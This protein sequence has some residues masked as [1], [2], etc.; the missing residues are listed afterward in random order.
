MKF[1]R[2]THS[3]GS[4]GRRRRLSA[5]VG[6]ILTFLIVAPP[7]ALA[8]RG[9]AAEAERRVDSHIPASEVRAIRPVAVIGRE[10]LELSGAINVWDFVRGRQSYNSLGLSR[11]FVLGSGRMALLVDG[12]PASGSTTAIDLDAL[13]ISA[14]ER[15]EILNDSAAA[16]HGGHAIGG[17]INIVLRHDHEGAEVRL[18]AERPAGAGGDAEH[19]SALWGGAI[20]SGHMVIGADVFRRDEIRNADRDFSRARWTPGGEFADTAGVSVGGNTVFVPTDD[21]SIARSLGDCTG[22]AYTGVLTEPNNVPGTGC[23]FAYDEI[24]WSWE[25]RERNAAFVEFRHPVSEDT[26]LYA[27]AQVAQTDVVQARF[28]PSVGTFSFVP[29]QTLRQELAQDPEI[30]ALP[31]RLTVAHRFVGHGNRDWRQDVDDFELAAGVRGRFAGAVGYDAYVQLRRYDAP[32]DGDTFVSESAVQSAIEE[33]RYDL[34]N[35]LSTAPEHLAA[36]RETGLHLSRDRGTDQRSAG[37]SVDGTAFTLPG[38]DARWA[39]GTELAFD[40][41]RDLYRYRDV[42]GRSHEPDDVLGSGGVSYKGERRRWSIFAD[43]A[44]P[45]LTD[46]DLALAAR[47]DD[48]DDVGEALSYQVASRY[49]LSGNLALRG[50]WSEGSRAPSLRA[51]NASDSILYPYVCDTGTFTGDLS[52]CQRQQVELTSG[53]NPDLKPDEATSFSLGAEAGFGPLSL[54]ADWFAIA[55]SDAPAELSPQ[56]IIDLDNEGRLPPGAAVVRDGGLIARIESPK[57]NAGETD[58][59]GFNLGARTEWNAAGTDIAID[60]HWMHVT[61]YETRVAG[62]KQPGDYPR[63]RVHAS[64]RASR[65]DL[66]ATW[67]VYGKSGFWN[68]PRTGRYAGWFGHDVALRWRNPFGWSAMELTGGMHNV[69]DR[70]PSTDST[71]P[72]SSGADTSLDTVRGRTLFLT[73]GVPFDP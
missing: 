17:A 65:G 13:P 16:L 51:L 66:T 56:T 49:G 39:A 4:P 18:G 41:A 61:R 23:G 73:V 62:E 8:P 32:V 40:D 10:D 27:D 9:A 6:P 47:L 58:A 64:L 14:V 48:H 3:P 21:G 29:S 38:G 30:D 70:G 53:G 50:S 55:I 45:L 36:I 11:P 20:G 37:A 22:S 2:A 72:G 42:H 59:R 68:S 28:A 63:N 31:E 54:S 67:S 24:A 5:A 57:V 15:I 44:L 60:T 46:W 26:E 25:R 12:R 19:G 69:G 43:T 33:G 7:S 1:T 35:P 71:L 52:E 34:E